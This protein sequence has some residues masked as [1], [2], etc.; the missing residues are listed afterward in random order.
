MAT[1]ELEQKVVTRR[2]VSEACWCVAN[3]Y[4]DTDGYNNLV[5]CGVVCPDLET[6]KAIARQK[7]EMLVQVRN[8]ELRYRGKPE[9]SFSDGWREVDHD[10]GIEHEYGYDPVGVEVS[11]AAIRVFKCEMAN[12]VEEITT[13]W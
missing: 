9:I 2:H 3:V 4:L 10:D 8:D 12:N 6:A 11:Y 5:S 1:T 13:K 7:A